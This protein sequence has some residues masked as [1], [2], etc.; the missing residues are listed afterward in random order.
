MKARFYR[1]K[2]EVTLEELIHFYIERVEQEDIYTNYA[3]QELRLI[4]ITGHDEKFADLM[5]G[6]KIYVDDL[7]EYLVWLRFKD[8]TDEALEMLSDF[9]DNLETLKKS[10]CMDA[11][12]VHNF[13]ELYSEYPLHLIDRSKLTALLLRLYQAELR[14][15]KLANNISE[16]DLEVEYGKTISRIG[17][18]ELNSGSMT[19]DEIGLLETSIDVSKAAFELQERLLSNFRPRFTERILENAVKVPSSLRTI[20]DYLLDGIDSY[21]D[22]LLPDYRNGSYLLWRSALSQLEDFQWPHRSCII[23]DSRLNKELKDFHSLFVKIFEQAI[24]HNDE[25]LLSLAIETLSS[26]PVRMHSDIL[27]EAVKKT[28][29]YK[30]RK[31]RYDFLNSL[32]N[33]P[34]YPLAE[35]LALEFSISDETHR[36]KLDAVLIKLTGAVHIPE[37]SAERSGKWLNYLR[38]LWD[39]KAASIEP[40]LGGGDKI[41]QRIEEV[42]CNELELG[43]NKRWREVAKRL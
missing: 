25:R 36:Q 20:M 35:E 6:I 42:T 24:E 29:L 14:C 11:I 15:Y 12:L 33:F 2:G 41:Q 10:Q 3:F 4:D 22:I 30:D 16:K 37:K 7:L 23:N 5:D 9:A 1:I 19:L 8:Y 18:E 17:I 26:K 32:V 13:E 28:A 43:W 39:Q 40:I 21:E 34:Y 31:L 27:V 38:N